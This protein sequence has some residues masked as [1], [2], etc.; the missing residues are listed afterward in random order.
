ME[1]PSGHAAR[2]AGGLA[3]VAQRAHRLYAERVANLS[4]AP[5]W[6]AVII[7]ASSD[8]QALVYEAE[9]RR[10][11]DGGRIPAGVTWL[12][13]PDVAG[14]RI[15]SGGATL[16]ALRV[17]VETA[18]VEA[19]SNPARWWTAERVL[20]L[21]SG[22]DS[23]RLPQYSPS[24]K[25]FSAL[26]VSTPW[27]EAST[28][29]DET[30]ALST[31]WVERL[32]AGLLVGSGDVLLTFDPAALDWS[33]PGVSGVAM[34]QPAETAA[35]HGVY[36]TD[37]QGR[38]YGFLQKP[39]LAELKA[40]GGIR[41]DGRAALDTGLIRFD[42]A[43]AAALTRL[44]GETGAEDEP[45][46][47]DLYEHFTRAL[48]GQWRPQAGDAPALHAVYTAL[49]GTPFWCSV[50]QGDFT[51]VGTTS[52]FRRLMT[53]E[54][55]FSRIYEAQQWLG[56]TRQP[57]VQSAGVV[58]DSVLSGGATL[59]AGTVVLEC[60]L[61]AP[62]RAGHGS[63]LHGL[64]GIT[65]RL[66]VPA[67]TAVHQ[68]P[69]AIPGGLRGVAI[70]AYGV[71]DDPKAPVAGGK[72][73]W[74]GRPILEVLAALGI[75]PESVWAG[76]PGP[77]RSLWNAELFPLG[78]PDDAWAAVGWL[79]KLAGGTPPDSW[80]ACPRLSLATSAQW[81]DGRA[82]ESSRIGR[83]KAA[84]CATAISLVESGA[85]IRPLLAN[86][87]GLVPLAETG[88]ALRRRASDGEQS[89]PTVA[90]AR[91]YA[92]SLFFGQAGLAADAGES[93]AAAFRMV[94]H[95][96]S[97]GSI[98]AAARFA[99]PWKRA[100]VTVDGPA[101]IDLGGGWSDTPPFCLDWGGAVLNVAV[102]LE[103]CSIAATVRRLAEPV[104]RCVSSSDGAAAE[105][106]TLDALLAPPAPGDPF[107]IPRTAL[108]MT[109]RFEP[110]RTLEE[111]LCSMGGGLEIR[112]AVNLPM[113][114]GLGT[115]SILG[116]TIVRALAEMAGETPDDQALSQQVMR[117]E[118]LMTTGGG[119]QDQVG[120]IF[121]GAKLATTGPGL[122]QRVRV[123]PVAWTPEREAEFENLVLLY[124]T[125]IR[126][127]AR[128]LLRQVV[129]RYLARETASVQVLH[130]I[131]TLAIEMSYAIE[132][133]DWDHLGELLDRHW[134][135]NQVLDPNTANAPINEVMRAVRP[136]VRG[137]KLAGAGGGGFLILLAKSPNAR[138]ELR[139][140]LTERGG[141][142]AVYSWRIAREGLRIT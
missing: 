117:L 41:E 116:A 56:A 40:G 124:Y 135:L 50:V 8:R 38:I 55:P 100:E 137:A 57:G 125:G 23:R 85:D 113:G 28:V 70:R 7:T 42:P 16:N 68:V 33:R 77:A 141:G 92:A 43:A 60:H 79:L 3:A 119:W 24:G 126:R 81:V 15:G 122:R 78:S 93:R 47:I 134:E 82:L 110:A 131:K 73:T 27:G 1:V 138:E 123:E 118:Q 59:G 22:G 103:G 107:S 20:I 99:G 102:R 19:R 52:L 94:R 69:V 30:M 49:E 10:R 2:E 91:Y 17:L 36:I 62:V 101:R 114:S 104:I 34:L 80:M 46:P 44:A 129:G 120:G 6:T 133:G 97:S 95:A 14:R 51:H 63:L 83:L 115:S 128:D 48:T 84:W 121:P 75:D 105:Y 89:A 142:G 37:E 26:P 65:G 106:R 112:T 25:L 58:I 13:V 109:G 31:L 53:G 54:T 127:V 139:R 61:A 18:G 9:L 4:P 67:D 108:R 29:F 111:A 88:E 76:V 32:A 87:P 11:A 86:A 96:V 39:S 21:H 136:Y 12:V 45:P 130:S 74:F 5:W 71:E 98:A 35:R 140:F 132:E 90:A 72:A 66:E 64:E